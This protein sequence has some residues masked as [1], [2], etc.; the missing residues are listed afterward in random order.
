VAPVTAAILPSREFPLSE[1]FDTF[2][3]PE[4]VS[5][6]IPAN[7]LMRVF[8]PSGNSSARN[9]FGVP[10][11]SE[12]ARQ[13]IGR[14]NRLSHLWKHITWSGEAGGFACDSRFLYGFISR[15]VRAEGGH[16][17]DRRRAAGGK[18]AGGCRHGSEQ[19]NH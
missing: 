14:R 1:N 11:L 3:F 10:T 19:R 12:L 8:G 5:D 16:W 6:A 7:T 9:L 13:K 15:L 18:V 17:I 4:V 2:C